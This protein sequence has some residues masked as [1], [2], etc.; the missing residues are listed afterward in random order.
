MYEFPKHEHEKPARLGDG[1]RALDP[2][3]ESVIPPFH[4]KDESC[5]PR[6]A[7][8]PQEPLPRGGLPRC[9]QFRILDTSQNYIKN[10]RDASIDFDASRDPC[11]Q[12]Q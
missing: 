3:E 9:E 8:G 5:P 11:G 2:P 6:V 7:L 10:C 4:Q 12:I 1:N